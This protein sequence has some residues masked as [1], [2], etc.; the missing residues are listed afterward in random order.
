[1]KRPMIACALVVSLAL[2]TWTTGHGDEGHGKREHPSAGGHAAAVGKPGNPDEAT[3]SIEVEMDDT[4]RYRPDRIRVKAGETIR[5][6]V[7][8]VGRLEHEMVLG[9]MEELKEHAE[10]MRKSP[11]RKHAE[12]NEVSV[13]PGKTGELIWRFTKAGTVHF[14][15]LVPGHFE[16]GMKGEIAVGAPAK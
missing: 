16:A 2:T 6:V 9:T 11:A 8:N 1:M 15:C 12:P 10:L 3:R 7:R 14:G 4:M 13:Q 5:F